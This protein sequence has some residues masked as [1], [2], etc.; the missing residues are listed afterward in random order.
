MKPQRPPRILVTDFDGTMTRFDFY[1]MALARLLPPEIPDYWEEYLTGRLTHFQA[2]QQLFAD[3]HVPEADVLAAARAME[4]DPA[5][6]PAVQRLQHA[7]WEI[8]IAS[9]GC[10]WYIERLLTEQG[11]NVTIAANPG[12]YDAERGLRMLP[13]LDSPYYSPATGIDKAAVVREA[14]ASG[15]PT[16]FAGDGRPDLPA[17][18]LVPPDHRFARGWLADHCRA[19][20]IPFHP[21]ERWSEIAEKLMQMG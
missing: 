17:L 9:A 16:A 18:L 5:C 11:I 6:A 2:L 14:L 12:T 8:R 20:G 3:I 13:P 7:G 4:L 21:F 10:A 19:E 1:R 15:A